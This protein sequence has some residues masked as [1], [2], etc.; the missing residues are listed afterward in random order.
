MKQKDWDKLELRDYPKREPFEVSCLGVEF[1]IR[2][3]TKEEAD[4]R[5]EKILASQFPRVAAQP[6]QVHYKRLVNE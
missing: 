6:H 4:A 5:S 2:A 3:A 1:K